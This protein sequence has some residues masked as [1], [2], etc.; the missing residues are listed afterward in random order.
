MV[1]EGGRR[2]GGDGYEGGNIVGRRGGVR[3]EEGVH[4]VGGET[5]ERRGERERTGRRRGGGK[6]EEG[7]RERERK[8][9]G[10]GEEG[11]KREFNYGLQDVDGS[12]AG[13]GMKRAKGVEKGDGKDRV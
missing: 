11:G 10:K 8:K 6:R 7:G 4:V 9:R 5:K 12:L 1:G 2:G 13:C 3:G